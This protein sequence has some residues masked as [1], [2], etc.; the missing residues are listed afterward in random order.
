MRFLLAFVF[1]GVCF[2]S[3]YP[4]FYRQLDG[5]FLEPIIEYNRV[6]LETGE[7]NNCTVSEY[8]QPV[9]TIYRCTPSGSYIVLSSP[10]SEF[11]I[12][13]TNSL[14][15]DSY[16]QGER[17]HQMSL[18]GEVVGHPKIPDGEKVVFY[19]WY[20]VQDA[21][22][23]RGSLTFKDLDLSKPFVLRP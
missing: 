6:H 19:F 9:M 10:S 3:D 20:P 22:K 17:N 21:K 16:Y 1:S 2:A 13:F 14:L 4:L 11:K 12:E 23:V 15:Q 8:D 5:E 18:I 7:F